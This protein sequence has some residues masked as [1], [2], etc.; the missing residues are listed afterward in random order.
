MHKKCRYN[1]K[2]YKACVHPNETKQRHF[3][4][5]FYEIQSLKKIKHREIIKTIYKLVEKI[6]NIERT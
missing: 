5:I 2:N 6:K 4:I 1:R 3:F